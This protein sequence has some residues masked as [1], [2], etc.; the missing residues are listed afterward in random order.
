MSRRY[1]KGDFSESHSNIANIASPPDPGHGRQPLV[2]SASIGHGVSR[3]SSIQLDDLD[4][5]QLF[6]NNSPGIREIFM[7]ASPETA[8][9]YK[10]R[11]RHIERY[12]IWYS[13]TFQTAPP[14]TAAEIDDHFCNTFAAWLV[15][16]GQPQSSLAAAMRFFI[17]VLRA[18]GASPSLI[19]SNP[20]HDNDLPTPGDTLSKAEA[21]KIVNQ[22]K[23]EIGIV[24]RRTHEAHRLAGSGHDPHRN[25]GGRHGD[26]QQPKN[27]AWVIKRL[28]NREIH[29]FED[30]RLNLGRNTLIRGL[31]GQPG[32][33]YVA[34]DGTIQRMV[35][36]MGHLRWF[37][38]W[39]DDMAPFIVLVMLRTGWNLSTVAALRT[40]SWVEPYPFRLSGRTGEDHV[41]VVSY[42]TRGRS[43]RLQ[44]SAV[45]KAPSSK[46][47][48]SHPYRL[49]KYLDY[50]TLALRK[51]MYRKLNELLRKAK[52][53][54]SDEDELN[55]LSQIKDDIFIYKSERG[56]TSLYWEARNG[57]T[58]GIQAFLQRCGSDAS[59]RD[60]RDA[61]I[62]FSY[63]TSGQ[64]LFVAQIAANHTDRETTALYVRRRRTQE[65]VWDDAVRLFDASL[66]L[67]Q[68]GDFNTDKVRTILKQQGLTS[69]QIDNLTNRENRA[70]WGNRCADPENPPKDFA[71]DA[72]GTCQ[73]QD[74][75]DGCPHARWFADS[76]EYVC[77]ELINAERL[78]ERLSL[79][80]TEGSSLESRINRCRELLT[81]WP[82]E[83]VNKALEAA[84]S[85]MKR[86]PDLFFGSVS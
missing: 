79:Q 10:G 7:N 63:E 59:V 24:K 3:T 56:I 58:R 71:R 19:P 67:I 68:S 75:I 52:L 50:L 64:N 34:P 70:R 57:K 47:P 40:R 8:D 48:W 61:T 83:T 42:K 9:G 80:S 16:P 22:A 39:A 46:R 4:R 45:V 35:G 36:W 81:R 28:L 21:R 38:P 1:R 33:E 62:L 65:R 78:H 2:I 20:F 25:A 26:W 51:E 86:E 84:K 14:E 73:S 15:L 27:R 53:E 17:R 74:C 72:A 5:V 55:K 31:E 76:V 32:A 11:L 66:S 82:A 60:L 49:L 23:F 29:S 41:Y 85:K 37:F 6:R 12:I 13:D 44:S 18:V 77:R 54:K 43:S 69:H 30:L